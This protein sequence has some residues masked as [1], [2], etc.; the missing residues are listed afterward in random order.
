MM[1]R[2]Q[3]TTKFLSTNDLLKTNAERKSKF[4]S[5][6][7]FFRHFSQTKPIKKS[8]S[9]VKIC[10]F[11]RVRMTFFSR[12]REKRLLHVEKGIFWHAFR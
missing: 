3:V 8:F 11:E 12:Q 9:W 6:G 7:R 4:Y 1:L 10:D 2:A 5:I